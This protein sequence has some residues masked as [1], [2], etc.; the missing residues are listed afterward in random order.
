[1]VSSEG[2]PFLKGI[3][4]VDIQHTAKG[5]QTW[6]YEGYLRLPRVYCGRGAF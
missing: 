3:N 2:R 4:R 6:D 5:R 1:M